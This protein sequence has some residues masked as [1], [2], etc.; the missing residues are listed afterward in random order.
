MLALLS[1]ENNKI[2]I[3]AENDFAFLATQACEYGYL[4]VAQWLIK[5]KYDKD[6]EIEKI[7]INH[8]KEIKKM[9][10]PCIN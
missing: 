1:I 2:N 9:I 3:S 5:I 4:E 7:K 10:I 8:I 6:I